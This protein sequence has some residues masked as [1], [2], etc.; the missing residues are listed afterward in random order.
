MNKEK[1]KIL[2]ESF[3]LSV[4][5]VLFGFVWNNDDPLFLYIEEN[6][7]FYVFVITLLTLYYG[8]VAGIISMLAFGL[9]AYFLYKKFPYE[10][11]FWYL[12][13][14]FIFGEFHYYWNRKKERLEEE[15][16]FLKE[17]IE[18]LGKNF[19]MLKI[20]H[21]QIEKNYVLKPLSIRSVLKEIRSMIANKDEKLFK[22][23]LMLIVR[24]TNVDGAALYIFENDDYKKVAHIGKDVELKKN[25]PLVQQALE[26]QTVTYVSVNRLSED[27]TS[28]Y[29][30]VIPAVD[31]NGNVRGLL[32]ITDMPFL[33]LNKDNLL[34]INVFLTYLFD[35]FY[36]AKEMEDVVKKFPNIHIS[37]IKELDKLIHLKRKF[38]IESS[39]IV[40]YMFKE[41][42]MDAVFIEIE[43]GLRGFDI[44]SRCYEEEKMKLIVLL[45]FTSDVGAI[46]FINRVERKIQEIFGE[47]TKEKVIHRIITVG[48]EPVDIILEKVKEM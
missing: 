32:L 22:N 47:G 4:L 7:T 43:K 20:S 16:S 28:E 1:F 26:D 19:F 37:F 10:T 6:I 9:S 18:E 11:F 14:T 46:E 38:G 15:N 30:A 41:D 40:F 45:P 8:L 13:L 24:F 2:F 48:K 12:L 31:I 36:L 29:L 34:T 39:V 23:F 44:S 25:D 35:E 5:F 33:S 17:K 3:F 27:I 21:D 42:F